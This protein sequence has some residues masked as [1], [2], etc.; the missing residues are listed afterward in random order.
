MDMPMTMNPLDSPALDPANPVCRRPAIRAGV[1]R[2]GFTL[3][4][5]LVVILIIGLVSAIALPTILP[6]LSH[7]QVSEA[8]RVLQGAIVGARDKAIH[9]G[10]PSGIRLLP[11]PN[12]NGINPGSLLVDPAYPL[13]YNRIVPIDPAPEYSEGMCTP[14][15][16]GTVTY[17]QNAFGEV[18]NATNATSTYPNAL[19][20]MENF[21][22][23][24]PPHHPLPPTSW[25]WNVRVGDKIQ[26]GGSGPWYT[27]V[28]PCLVNPTNINTPGENPELFVNVG[29]PAPESQY[30][31][32]LPSI[33]NT[34]V[35]YLA[36]VNGRD[37]NLNGWID[38]GWDGIDN[39]GINGPDDAGE[40][41]KETWHASVST[42]QV[43]G[44]SYT[45]RRRPLPGPNA[46]EIS[47]PSNMVV[48]ATTWGLTKERSRLPVDRFTGFVDI[49]IN[50]DGTVFYNSPYGTPASAGMSATFYHF[51]LADRSDLVPIDLQ[52]SG[53][54]AT[55]QPIETIGGAPHYLPIA[56]PGGVD[57]NAYALPVLKGDYSLLT[58]VGRTGQIVVNEAPPFDDPVAA[59]SQSRPFNVGLPFVETQQG[60]R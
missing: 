28:G 16:P 15:T 46:R 44:V 54:V 7:R 40:W 51:W 31:S 48:D 12:F 1:R 21:V 26:I 32:L 19:I 11:D 13:A 2:A 18:V 35:Q 43:T 23:P 10:Q 58:L 45:I 22:D 50:P 38:E 42:N 3:I 56:Q 52:I 25:F 24:K 41:E 9:D 4:E 53:T 33:A 34:A 27:V 17:F 39:D 14:L 49:M 47:L 57:S 20:L 5:L 29:M 59:A 60:M 6:A 30:A 55:P 36:L 8:G 37:D